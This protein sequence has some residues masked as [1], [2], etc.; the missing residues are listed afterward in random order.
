MLKLK[1]I[2]IGL[3]FLGY[4]FCQDY[5]YVIEDQTSPRDFKDAIGFGDAEAYF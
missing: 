2:L 3:I 1:V 4:V 5:D